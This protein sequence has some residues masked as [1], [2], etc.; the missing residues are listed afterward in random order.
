MSDL[1]DYV[2]VSCK[3]LTLTSNLSL[4][5][6]L[7]L[8][9]KS[10]NDKILS[11]HREIEYNST[12]F[13]KTM[14]NINLSPSYFLTI[15]NTKP[16]QSGE[17]AYIII[18]PEDRPIVV[19]AL[20]H[21]YDEYN[22]NFSKI[23]AKR[24]GMLIKYGKTNP[25]EISDLSMG[26]YLMIIFDIIE[27]QNGETIPGF[28]INLSSEKNY[29]VLTEKKFLAF[30]DCLDKMDMFSYAMDLLNYVGRPELGTNL[31]NMNSDSLE[32][33]A[34]NKRLIGSNK[35]SIWS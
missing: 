27:N 22:Q 5:I 7:I 4:K 32:V 16:S 9:D 26:K 31:F 17:K 13:D 2:K 3:I 30:I 24:K 25:I 15:E 8:Q 14:K 12:K 34:P 10:L 28:R 21:A 18:L 20:K 1:S 19:R 11:V 23:Y 29:V 35:K 6:V 33:S